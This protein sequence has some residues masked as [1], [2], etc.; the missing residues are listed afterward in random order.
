VEFEYASERNGDALDSN[1]WTFQGGY[2]LSA[3]RW[4][5]TLSY[6]YASFQGDDTTTSKNEAFD[7]LFLGFYDWGTWWQG[8][9][10]G[11]YFLSNSNLK[12]HAIRTH[13]APNDAVGGGLIFYVFRLDRPE[14]LGAQVTSK[15]AAFEVD[16][17]T[18]WKVNAN[19][20]LSIV[21]AYADPGK[22]VQ[23]LTGRTKNF[24]YGMAYVG[25]SF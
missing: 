2:E 15:E 12:S 23:Q 11:E 21:G 20:T 1:A 3:V 8:E 22:A 17:Y 13:V 4:K 16:A 10:A 24:A 18:D 19:F 9:I 14:S 25:Y 6:R 7:P 5:P